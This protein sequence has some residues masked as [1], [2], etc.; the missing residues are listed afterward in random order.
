[1]S[2]VYAERNFIFNTELG[3]VTQKAQLLYEFD[4]EDI[5]RSRA[6]SQAKAIQ[7]VNIGNQADLNARFPEGAVPTAFT[8][9]GENLAEG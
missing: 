7:F 4:V 5:V 6:L 2:R 1:M 9:S 8:S 3:P